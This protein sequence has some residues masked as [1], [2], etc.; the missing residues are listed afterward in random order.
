MTELEAELG[1]RMGVDEVDD[2]PPG[3]L[4]LVVPQARVQPSVMRA[5]GDTQVISVKTSPAPPVA[6]EP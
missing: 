5:C 3:R 2:A 4:L 1:R 6:R